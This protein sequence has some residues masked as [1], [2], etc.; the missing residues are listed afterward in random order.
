MMIYCT[1]EDKSLISKHNK[2]HYAVSRAQ[3]V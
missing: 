3:S 2:E 1:I